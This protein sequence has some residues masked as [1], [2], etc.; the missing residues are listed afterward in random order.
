M[1]TEIKFPDTRA[2]FVDLFA[3]CGGF[4]LGFIMAMMKCVGAMEMAKDAA[5]TYWF[6]LCYNGWSHLWIDE[7]DTKTIEWINKRWEGGK[8]QNHLWPDGVPDNWLEVETPMPCSNLF[9]MD[10][11]KIEPEE[12]LQKIGMKAGDLG[13]LIGGPPRQV[14]PAC[15]GGKSAIASITFFIKS[16]FS[17]GHS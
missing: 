4:S 11:L 5:W 10:I 16:T 3:G 12:F 2:T 13:C 7:N 15:I 8:T 1:Q 17:D 9:L 14:S 6:N